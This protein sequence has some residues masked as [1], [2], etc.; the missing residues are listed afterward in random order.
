MTAFSPSPQFT[1]RWHATPTA[2][3]NAFHQELDDIIDMLH[4]STPAHEFEFNHADFGQTV[5]DLFFIHR[6]DTPIP[7]RI[8]HNLETPQAL[9]TET[10]TPTRRLTP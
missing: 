10:S 1:K 4:G 2:I 3:K 5:E 7:A 8:I 9:F 6:D